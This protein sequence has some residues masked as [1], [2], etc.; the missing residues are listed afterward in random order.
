MRPDVRNLAE[1]YKFGR[2]IVLIQGEEFPDYA[3]AWVYNPLLPEANAPVYAWDMSIEIR[4]QVLQAYQDR[5]VWIINGP[6]V[7]QAGYKVIEG[8]I[9][10]Q[11]LLNENGK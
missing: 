6:S 5:P 7:T 10:A 9:S 11:E 2:S 8:P 1:E 3:S 4:K